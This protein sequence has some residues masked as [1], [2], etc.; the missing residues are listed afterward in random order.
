MSIIYRPVIFIL[1]YLCDRVDPPIPCELVRGYL[2]FSPHAWNNI[3]VRRGS[4]LVRMVVDACHPTDIR[5]V[6]DPEFFC[7]SIAVSFWC[8]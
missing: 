2:D 1:Q 8:L 7:R 5:E 4:S 3:L 6:T